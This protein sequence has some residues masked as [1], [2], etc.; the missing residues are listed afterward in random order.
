MTQT[1][2]FYPGRVFGVE[3]VVV[4]VVVVSGRAAALRTVGVVEGLFL[5]LSRANDVDVGFVR[6]KGGSINVVGRRGS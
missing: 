5:S 4:V 1:V 2:R 3:A 6:L